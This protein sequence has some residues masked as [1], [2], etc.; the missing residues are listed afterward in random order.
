MTELRMGQG[1]RQNSRLSM[2]GL[3]YY[4]Q[5]PRLKLPQGIFWSD[6]DVADVSFWQGEIDFKKMSASGISG[7]IIRAGQAVW[8][9]RKFDDNWKG[10]REAGLPRGSYWF[11]D[12][13]ARP[14]DQAELWCE[15]LK[16]DPGEL[17]FVVDYE[18][19]YGGRY[20]GWRN[21]Y[22]FIEHLKARRVPAEKIWIYTGY[23][24]WMAKGPKT[25]AQLN[26]FK[27]YPLHI[28][29]YTTDPRR[30]RIPK[31]WTDAVMWQYGTPVEGVVR[32]VSSKE[33]DMNKFTG[34]ESDF[35]RLVR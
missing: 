19:N 15:A 4:P 30:V 8:K 5:A 20:A 13:R 6:V 16:R 9:D 11:Y 35:Q 26:Y 34:T 32:G 17:P 1:L 29:S 7:V 31:P 25:A 23:W 33:I 2:A 24:Y 10:A 21:L 28:A 27:Q 3:L 14:K 12:S 22:D 18:E